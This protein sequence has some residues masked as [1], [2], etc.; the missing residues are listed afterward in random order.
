MA[1]RPAPA[2]SR[3]TRCGSRRALTWIPLADLP[4]QGLPL[5]VADPNSPSPAYYRIEVTPPW[6]RNQ[7]IPRAAGVPARNLLR[8]NYA[9]HS[10]REIS[11]SIRRSRLRRLRRQRAAAIH[12]LA[13]CGERGAQPGETDA[14]LLQAQVGGQAVGAEVVVKIRLDRGQAG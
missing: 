11:R 5:Q 12:G 8:P 13:A 7:P 3:S 1:P 14:L 4:G 2:I 9:A 10:G 6:V